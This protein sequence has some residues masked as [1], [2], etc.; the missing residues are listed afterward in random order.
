MSDLTDQIETNSGNPKRVTVDGQSVE[1]HSLKDQ[2]EADRHLDGQTA[3]S[4][5]KPGIRLFQLRNRGTT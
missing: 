2:I 3:K 1:Q 5:N 4:G